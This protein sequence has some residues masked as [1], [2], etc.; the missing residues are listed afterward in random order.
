MN[1]QDLIYDLA[2]EEAQDVKSK[3]HF[4][5]FVEKEVTQLSLLTQE[6][7]V[8]TMAERRSAI[9]IEDYDLDL[10]NEQ[11][12]DNIREAGTIYNEGLG[13]AVTNSHDGTHLLDPV[14]RELWTTA[15]NTL[16]ELDEYLKPYLELNEEDYR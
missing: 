9:L 13:D 14:A 12:I 4:E 15:H 5:A 16:N 2:V 10:T 3:Y 6:Q 8:Q 11:T 1:K 7:L